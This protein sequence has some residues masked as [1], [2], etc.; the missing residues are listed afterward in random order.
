MSTP[1]DPS[2]ERPARRRVLRLWFACA[3]LLAMAAAVP[4]V[5]SAVGK[6][7][8]KTNGAYHLTVR[9]YCTGEGQGTVR[10]K[11]VSI[12]VPVT[13]D[14]GTAG[15]LVANDLPLDGDHFEGDGTVF[16]RPAK[17]TGR[18]DG[19]DGDKHFRRARLLCSFT[20][21]TARGGRI[22]GSLLRP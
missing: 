22:A 16:G 9:G 21:G 11:R 17:F 19:Y 8:K 7:P 5:V 3:L 20:E 13:D 12:E 14:S 2:S 10:G 18:L 1:A 15:T 4:S 6:Q